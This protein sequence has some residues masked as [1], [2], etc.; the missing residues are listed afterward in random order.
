MR[1]GQFVAALQRIDPDGGPL[2]FRCG[3]VS[4]LDDRVRREIRDLGVDGTVDPD[5]TTAVWEM[6]LNAPAWKDPPRWVHADLNP[7][8]LLARHGRL[9]AVIDFGGLGVGDPAII[10]DYQR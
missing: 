10:N 7:V 4:N 3:P 8:N 9:T 2:S 6:A 5:L 1:L